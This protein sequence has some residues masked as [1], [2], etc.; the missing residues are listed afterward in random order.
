MSTSNK[1]QVTENGLLRLKGEGVHEHVLYLEKGNVYVED[2]VIIVEENSKAII[3][4]QKP[5]GDF[6]EHFALPFEVG[7]Y[8]EGKQV[9]S[10]FGKSEIVRVLD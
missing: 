6:A 3:K 9:T 7:D 4:H 1:V 10:P 8:I 5:N 2:D